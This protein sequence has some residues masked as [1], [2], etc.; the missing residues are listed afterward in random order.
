LLDILETGLGKKIDRVCCPWRKGDQ[1]IYV[2]DISKTV[3]I[4]DW[5]PKIGVMEGIK[6]IIDHVNSI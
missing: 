4:L 6:K 5:K 2:S 3:E 1:K